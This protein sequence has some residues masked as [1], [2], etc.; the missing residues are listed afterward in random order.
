MKDYLVNKKQIINNIFAKSL[1]AE[2]IVKELAPQYID[3]EFLNKLNKSF[4]NVKSFIKKYNVELDD[5]KNLSETEKDKLFAIGSFL[6]KNAGYTLND[7]MFGITLTREE[8]KFI[9]TAVERKLSYDGTEV[10]NMISLNENVLQEWHKVDDSLPKNIPT[11]LVKTDINNVVMLYHFLVKHSVKGLDK[12]FYTFASVLN[13]I[14][15]TNK[16]F[17]AYNVM[18]ERLNTDFALWTSALETE[19]EGTVIEPT[20]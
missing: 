1:E 20:K 5:V 7:L 19:T 12:E 4:D 11:M 13:K 2:N 9:Y 14:A 3:E 16:L 15:D 17:N 6:N 8:Y 10:F 18:K